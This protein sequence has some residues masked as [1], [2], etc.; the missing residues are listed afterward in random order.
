MIKA[1]KTLGF[2]LSLSVVALPAA[3]S[4]TP[5]L[6][7]MVRVEGGTFLQGS[8]EAQYA[9]NE[10]VHQATLSPFLIADTE[11]TQ[12]LWT[13]VMGS[14]PSRF[15]GEDRPVEFVSWLDAVRFCNALSEREGLESVYTI[16]GGEV[17]W[18]RAANGFRLPTESEWE[19]AARGG[20]LGAP[21]DAPLKRSPFAGGTEA[22]AVAW[23]D[24][25]SGKTTHPVA[26]KASNELGLYDLSGNVWEWCWDWYGEYP[27]T[28]VVDSE[29]ASKGAGQKVLRG[30]AW[31]TPQNLLR[32]TYRYWNAQSFKVNSV[33]FRIARNAGP[34]SASDIAAPPQDPAS[35]AAD[36]FS[37]S[38]PSGVG[39][40]LF[41]FLAAPES[42]R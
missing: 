37:K 29:G 30:G 7:R 11:T 3:A 26:Q 33:G 28:D 32:V 17:T 13:A 4:S 2:L 36:R 1:L 34:A 21:A 5:G 23:Y 10:R 24:Q 9:A 19:Y 27:R 42:E 40:D 20:Q 41:E 18:N 15:R 16:A 6:P 39:L 8:A 12:K 38:I 35:V 14:N 22:G 31:F 25:N